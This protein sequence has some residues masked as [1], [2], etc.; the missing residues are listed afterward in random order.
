MIAEHCHPR[1]GLRVLIGLIMTLSAAPL[2]A[3]CTVNAG[4]VVFGDYDT[5]SQQALD[6]AGTISV[7]CSPATSY[8]L[9]LSTGG[10]SYA[11]RE[12]AGIGSVLDY[13]LYT[14]VSRSIVWGDGSGS[15]ATVSGEG[16]SANHTVYGRIPAQQNVKAG[17]YSDSIVV[18]VTF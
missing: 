18:T 14:S 9:A 2:F 8:S 17:S 13:N 7:S 15:S 1:R 11:Q 10:G 16:D 4:S 12:L 5:L 6:G 3:N